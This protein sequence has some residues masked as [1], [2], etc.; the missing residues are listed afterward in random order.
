MAA[1]A[2]DE[3][4]L[5]AVVVSAAPEEIAERK[6][7]SA[8][9]IVIGEEDV[10]RFGDATVGDVLRRLPGMSFT[11]P[12]GVSKDVRMRGLD[13][14]Y[15]QFLI[16]GEPVPGIAQER[17]M[18]V[19]RLP[20]D[21][22][23]RIEIIRLPTA[24]LTA[25]GIAGTINIVLK[26]RAEDMTR[27]RVAYG[28]NGDENVGDV[29]GQWSRTGDDI[30]LFV[31]LSHTVGAEDVVED[32]RQYNASG[33]LTQREYKPKPVEKSETLLSPRLVWRLGKDKLTLE[34]FV[35]DGT[36]DKI[37]H[38]AISNGAGVLTR[39]VQVREDKTDQLWRFAGRY[40]AEAAWGRWH[41]KFG[42]QS[43][44]AE[45]DKYSTEANA[46][47]TVTKRSQEW[48]LL[49]ESQDYLGVGAEL[50]VASLPF[51]LG[52]EWRDTDYEKNKTTASANNAT[53]PLLPGAPGANDIY[54]IRERRIASYL[55]T[56]WRFAESHRL[57]PGLRYERYERDATDR[58]GNEVSADSSSSNPSLH[59]LW[60]LNKQWQLRASV[61]QTL[62]MPKF[63]DVNPLVSL[64][65]GA[66]AGSLANPDKGGNAALDPEKAFGVELGLEHYLAD[67]RGVIGLNFY[68][69]DVE[70]YVS[71]FVRLEGTRYVRRPENVGDAHFWGAELDWRLPLLRGG[72]HE[73]TLTGSHAE[74]RGEVTANADAAKADVKD[75]P[76]RITNLGLD[77]AH[78][79][80]GFS[81]GFSVHHTP[82]FDGDSLNGDGVR[83]VKHRNA[84][85]LLDLYAGKRLTADLELR[86][87]AKNVLQ[88]EKDESTIKYRNDGTINNTEDKTET[89]EPT[90]FLV[91]ENRF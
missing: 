53:D 91:L 3:T 5:K 82:A 89:S 6:T 18:Q 63:D 57:T 62:K 51:K 68:D 7:E 41:G 84:A 47:G 42:S 64:A 40:D 66:G 70:D 10:E 88:V 14:G 25:S 23:E 50:P 28:R 49:D 13:K 56:D 37:E 11:G 43:G 1:P 54:E 31:G 17:Q 27:L 79:S 83:E 61:A 76:P 33:A 19:D 35:S 74:L 72:E 81:A 15:T 73:L 4:Q 22:I 16:N 21:M 86:L 45:K 58:L 60:S 87:I 29:I 39:T 32:K 48:E 24:D 75:L 36:E 44:E 55:Q 12:A 2:A 80:S 26:R 69:R 59:Y 20:A 65:T 78:V 71:G 30:D 8:Q 90:V 46:A 52:V 85:T 38:S 34:P 77:W 67:D 9:K